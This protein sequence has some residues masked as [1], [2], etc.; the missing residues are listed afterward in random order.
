MNTAVTIKVVFSPVFRAIFH[1][2][3]H[4]VVLPKKDASIRGLLFQLSTA[5]AGKIDKLVFEK[6]RALISTGLMVQVNDRTYTGNALNRQS[7]S[8]RDQDIVS[9]LYYISGG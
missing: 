4:D 1:C 3:E 6:E 5:S 8:L 7:V 9:L 2:P